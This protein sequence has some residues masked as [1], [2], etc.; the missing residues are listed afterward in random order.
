MEDILTSDWFYD[1]KN[2][3]VRIKSPIE[4]LAGM[5][6]MLPME[7]DNSE[8]LLLVQ[9][10]LGQMLFYPPNVAGW[11]GGK[12][13]IDSSTLMLRLRLPQLISDKDD[14]N[15]VPKTDDDQSMGRM[16][17]EEVTATKGKANK[18]LGKLGK[19]IKA[20]IEW[21]AYTKNFESIPRESLTK[22]LMD[23]LFQ[24]K[25]NLI[26]GALKNYVDETGRE[27][28]I[29]TATIQLMSTPEYQMC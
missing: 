12:T 18:R 5:Q 22:A 27:N 11:P 20:D 28:F 29:K 8:A 26:T 16:E 13:W 17:N 3:G 15:V 6:R 21:N 14:F 19:L 25:T 2:I 9:R 23:A 1:E 24:T 4:L 10:A 7:L